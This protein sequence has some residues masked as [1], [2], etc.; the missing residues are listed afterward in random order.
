M[1]KTKDFL[2]SCRLSRY[3]DGV[4]FDFH[5]GRGGHTASKRGRRELSGMI[6]T[7]LH[8]RARSARQLALTTVMGMTRT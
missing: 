6:S 2:G 8:R 7:R 1:N 4:G 3:Q 5:G